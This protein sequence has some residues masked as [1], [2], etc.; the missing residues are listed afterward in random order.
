MP[1]HIDYP[2]PPEATSR[3]E[4]VY[5]SSVVARVKFL[6]ASA[7]VRI[8]QT[9][10]DRRAQPVFEFRFR[11]V[12]YLK[13]SGDDELT[14]RV[15][16]L[17][18]YDSIIYPDANE[19]LTLMTAQSRLDERDTHWDGREAVVFLRPSPISAE[20]ESGVYEFADRG[21]LSPRL[22]SYDIASSRNR[23][24]LPAVASASSS[25]SEPRYL[26]GAPG[27]QSGAAV[28]AKSASPSAKSISLSEMKALVAANEDIV[29][30]GKNVPG[31]A[32]CI[33][34]KFE[35]DARYKRDPPDM[36]FVEYRIPS[37][38]TAG[39]R[40]AGPYARAPAACYD[41]Q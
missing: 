17:D 28:A 36:G 29:A 27:A 9:E 23:A 32:D 7:G 15:V 25:S 38:Q 13:G 22:D 5:F 8:Y 33:E 12:E 3:E 26:T 10:D 34:E 1:D 37:G 16:A 14:V 20:A 39:Y 6:S 18:R 2:A 4:P 30:K 19:A 24:W 11:V 21:D 41:W 40:I 31:Y 35:L